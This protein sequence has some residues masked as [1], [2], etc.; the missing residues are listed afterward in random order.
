MLGIGVAGMTLAEL[1]KRAAESGVT[2]GKLAVTLE[3]EETGEA[4]EYVVARLREMLGVMASAIHE[5]LRDPQRRSRSGLTGGDAC[6]VYARLSTGRA[7]PGNDLLVRAMAYALAVSEV[8]ASMGKVVAAPTAGS[9]GIIPGCLF[10]VKETQ[11][12]SDQA[13]LDAL[14]TAG[15]VGRVIAEKAT[16]SGAEGGCQAECG[17]AAAMAAAGLA[18]LG[19]GTPEDCIHAAALALK[20]LLGLVCDPVAGLVEVPCVKRN[21]LCCAIAIAAAEMALAGVRSF[22]PPDEVIQA[23]AQVGRCLPESLKETSRGGLAATET[24]LRVSLCLQH[25]CGP[26]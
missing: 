21:A 17:S 25:T 10:A 22:I 20:G 4:E 12:L 2:L 6:K 8:N 14:C 3:V 9:C 26:Q 15:L 7:F 24:A 19:G 11:G 5:G 23:M 13:V 18:Q 16:L 1:A